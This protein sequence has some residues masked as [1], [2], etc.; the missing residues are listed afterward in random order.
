LVEIGARPPGS[1]GIRRAQAYNIGQ[2]KSF[3]CQFEEHD[4][5]AST[6]LGDVAMKN[7]IAKIPGTSSDIVL[8]STYYDTLRMANFV[9]ADDGGSGTGTM[10]E[11]ARIFCSKKLGSPGAGGVLLSRSEG[12]RLPTPL[13]C[14]KQMD[15]AAFPDS[16]FVR[17]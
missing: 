6:P 7:I 9:G 5:H 15:M 11:L 16:I 8:Y 4:F 12:N 1:D 14:W 3:G 10:L 2:L 17:S 13:G